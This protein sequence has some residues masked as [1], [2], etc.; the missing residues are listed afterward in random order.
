MLNCFI[1]CCIQNYCT[2]PTALGL[3][4]NPHKN[5]VTNKQTNKHVSLLKES[6]PRAQHKLNCLQVLSNDEIAPGQSSPNSQEL[7][8]ETAVATVSKDNTFTG[9]DNAS[10]AHV[11]QKPWWGDA[12]HHSSG[13]HR[14]WLK[15]KQDERTND[16]NK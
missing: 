4:Y 2:I 1:V 14:F 10:T 13:F 8:P 5:I 11:Q 12:I 9:R 15:C 16:N 7:P 3:E 6:G